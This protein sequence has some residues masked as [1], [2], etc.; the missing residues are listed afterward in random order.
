M[1]YELTKGQEK[2]KDLIK[3][4]FTEGKK[5][6]PVFVLTGYAGTGK[7]FLLNAIIKDEL[8]LRDSDIAFIAPTGKAASV[9]TQKGTRATTIHQ[10]IYTPIDRKDKNK[11]D[12]NKKKVDFIR[13]SSIGNLK[14]IVIDEASMLSQKILEDVMSFHIPI[15]LSGDK[16]QLP[17]IGASS[18]LLDKPDINLD[19]VVRQSLDSDIIKLSIKIRNKEKLPLGKFGDDVLVLNRKDIPEESLKKIYLNCDQ[20]ICGR[21]KTRHAINSLVRGYN[22]AISR[23]PEVG[24]KIICTSNNWEET[25]SK[26]NKFFLVNGTM[27][28][29]TETEMKSEKLFISSLKFKPDFLESETSDLLFDN[30]YYIDETYNYESQQR[31]AELSDGSF[32]VKEVISKRKEIETDAQYKARLSKWLR[33]RN[34]TKNEVQLNRFEF[35]YAISCHKSQGSE[36]DTVVLIDESYVF[37]EPERWLYTGI[38]RA[39]KKLIIIK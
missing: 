3:E 38:T 12:K 20:I 31:V 11:D 9:L 24:D 15:L 6:N 13:K 33:E 17:A 34:Q 22:G 25:I 16:G 39:K 14:L 26:D 8:R 35:A 23:Y 5:K 21:N 2:A 28:E 29:V 32:I 36:F 1:N 27:G 30:H 10:L 18:K 7:T 4:W 37:P 19:E